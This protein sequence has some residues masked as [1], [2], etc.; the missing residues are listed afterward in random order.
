MVESQSVDTPSLLKSKKEIHTN[1]SIQENATFC[2][3]LKDMLLIIYLAIDVGFYSSLTLLSCP[4]VDNCG[5][6]IHGMAYHRVA[7]YYNIE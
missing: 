6:N 3:L 1:L 2:Y 4:N 7:L 5:N